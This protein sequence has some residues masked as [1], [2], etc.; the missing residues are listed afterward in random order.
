MA[1]DCGLSPLAL[2]IAGSMSA[3]KGR[4]S[5]ARAWQELHKNIENK[6]KMLQQKAGV[7]ARSINHILAVGYDS[8]GTKKKEEFASLAVLPKAAV[9]PTDMLQNLWDIEV[10]YNVSASLEGDTPRVLSRF[11]VSF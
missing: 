2:T 11:C 10:R 7:V 9:A 8:L 3:V 4:G 6:R 5:S 1:R